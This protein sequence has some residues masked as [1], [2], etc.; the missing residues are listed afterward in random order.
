[1]CGL[2]HIMQGQNTRSPQAPYP[3]EM[4]SGLCTLFHNGYPLA[5]WCT[6][7]SKLFRRDSH[8]YERAML[9]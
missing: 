4:P 8:F 5:S 2:P 7:P 1:R 3:V 9:N 6:L